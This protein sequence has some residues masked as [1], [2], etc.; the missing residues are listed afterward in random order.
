MTLSHQDCTVV[1]EKIAA[2]RYRATC[3]LF[4][5]G[6]AF[7]ATEQDARRFLEEAMERIVQERSN[8]ALR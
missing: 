2:N 1:V 4:P 3:H 7:G 8:E 5:D 6:E